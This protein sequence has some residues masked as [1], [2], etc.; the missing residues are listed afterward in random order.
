V[1]EVLGVERVGSG[2]NFFDLGGHS[3]LAMRLANRLG[4]AFGVRLSVRT[5][6]EARTLGELAQTLSAA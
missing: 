2:D 3:L 5:I 1:A 6:F 4:K